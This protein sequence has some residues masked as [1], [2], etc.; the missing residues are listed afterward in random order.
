MEQ[1]EGDPGSAA[2]Q[3]WHVASEGQQGNPQTLTCVLFAVL[4]LLLPFT[5]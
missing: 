2:E 1:G 4:Q 5:V 3:L